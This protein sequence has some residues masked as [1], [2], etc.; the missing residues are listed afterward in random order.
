[1]FS[2]KNI[3]LIK[4]KLLS[5]T[6]TK[7]NLI[8]FHFY[9]LSLSILFYPGFEVEM[10]AAVCDKLSLTTIASSVCSIANYFSFCFNFHVTA[11][12]YTIYMFMHLC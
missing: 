3:L 2:I 5:K 12:A 7:I 9:M 1:M 4:R 10:N 11:Y 8:F 6:V